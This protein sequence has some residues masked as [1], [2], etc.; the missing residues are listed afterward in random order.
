MK[1]R[2]SVNNGVFTE[3]WI[4]EKFLWEFKEAKKKKRTS[5][6]QYLHWRMKSRYWSEILCKSWWINEV[7]WFYKT[8]VVVMRRC[9]W[10]AYNGAWKCHCCRLSTATMKIVGVFSHSRTFYKLLNMVKCLRKNTVLSST[11]C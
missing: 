6:R 3:D 7:K 1:L 5:F 10:A 11:S 8:K 9:L 4:L 2:I